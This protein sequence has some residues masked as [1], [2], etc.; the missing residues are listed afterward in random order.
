MVSSTLS[1]KYGHFWLQKSNMATAKSKMAMV[2]L[3]HWRLQNGSLQTNGWRQGDYVYIF[4]SLCLWLRNVS[5]LTWALTGFT[6]VEGSHLDRQH[7]NECLWEEVSQ[8]RGLCSPAVPY[9]M[10]MRFSAPS[11][12]AVYI[13]NEMLPVEIVLTKKMLYSQS[14]FLYP[15]HLPSFLWSHGEFGS[16]RFTRCI[17]AAQCYTTH[18]HSC[19][20][21]NRMETG[22]SNWTL[23]FTSLI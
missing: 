19:C 1:S 15:P 13:L 10:T 5:A 9:N 18:T 8:W 6:A 23:H 3:L 17:M 11:H 4:Y 14:K 2:K 21:I 7:R 16:F 20:H 12:H 22:L